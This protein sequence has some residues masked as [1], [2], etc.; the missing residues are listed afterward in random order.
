MPEFASNPGCCC[1][2][3]MTAQALGEPQAAPGDPLAPNGKPIWALDEVMAQ[4]LRWNARWAGP[5]IAYSFYEQRPAYRTDGDYSGFVPFNAEQRAALRD[6]LDQISEVVPLTFTEA[7]DNQVEPGPA[8][9][10]ISFGTSGTMPQFVTGWALVDQSPGADLGGREQMFGAEVWLNPNRAVGGYAYGSRMY[11]VLMHEVL[12]AIGLPH[13]GLYNR[14]PNE[15]ILYGVHAQFFQDS[16]QYTVMSYFGAHETGAQHGG[17]YA[18]TPMLY[19]IEALQRYY[20]ENLA[21]RAGDTVYGFNST[22]GRAVYDF[23]QQAQPVVAIWDGGGVDT[24]DLSG[25]AQNAL[26]DLNPG[27]FSNAGG[28]VGNIAIALRATIENG[29]GGAGADTLI[30]NAVANRLTGGGGGDVLAGRGGDDRLE[31]GEGTDTA[32][33]FNRSADYAWWQVQDGS[34]RV[35]DLSAGGLEGTDTLVSVEQLAFTDRTIKLAGATTAEALG[36]AFEQVMRITAPTGGDAAFLSD[37]AASVSGGSKTLSQAYADIV[38]R[39]EG[40]T[41]VAA[42][43]YQFFLGYAPSKGGFDFLVNPAGPNPNSLGSSYYQ[44][45]NTE[46]RYINFAVNLGKLGEGRAAFEAD[47]GS[48][49][50]REATFEAYETIFG[51]APSD[52]FL[53]LL[54]DADIGG[55]LTRK[56]YFAYYGGDGLAG[57]GTKAAMVGWLLTEA[58]KADVGVFAR[59]ANAYLVDLADGAPFLVD[60]VG[61]YAQPGWIHQPGG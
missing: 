54:L 36:L 58:A 1:A 23:S 26:L 5:E 4:I 39:A 52:S 53:S 6:V 17:A 2:A 34:W 47:Y 21:T 45:F 38:Q 37:L 42:M 31:G 18:I 15:E 27:G 51:G 61:V 40:S 30:G 48:L 13:P 41:A 25:Y 28:L 16:L 9:S 57:L 10:R 3:C 55:G 12:H 59:S 60:M 43:S 35:Q 19:D 44:S 32:A 29:V 56:D 46:N 33:H 50:L 22:A 20:G 24:L 49:T 8:N 14:N 7:P 11:M